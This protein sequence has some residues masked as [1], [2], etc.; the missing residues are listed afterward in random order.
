MAAV[1]LCGLTGQECVAAGQV[2]I[3]LQNLITKCDKNGQVGGQ[4]GILFMNGVTVQVNLDDS[5]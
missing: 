4:V 3:Q 5:T 2:D 1:N